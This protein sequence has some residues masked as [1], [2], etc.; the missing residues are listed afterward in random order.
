MKV[1]FGIVGCG[2]IANF[3]AKAIEHIRGARIAACTDSVPASAA[4]FAAANRCTAYASV[5]EM[6]A[7]PAVDVVTI[8]TPSG[9]HKEPAVAA[10]KRRQARDRRKAAGDHA[11]A[12]RRHH[13]CLPQKQRPLGHDLPFAV[14]RRQHRRQGGHL[15]RP[16]WQADARRRV[17]QMVADPT[18][19]RQRRLAR[20]LGARR[21]RGLHEPGNSQRRFAL[22]VHGRSGRGLRR[23]GDSRA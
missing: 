1:G 7:D 5:R 6:L 10:A 3:H 17:R 19:L 9:A 20:H 23:D 2:M 13:Q 8:C 12:V 18:V 21:R 4:R 16:V 22:L 15:E 11:Q 14:Q